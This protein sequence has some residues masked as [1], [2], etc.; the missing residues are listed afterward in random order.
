MSQ[1]PGQNVALIHLTKEERALLRH[2]LAEALGHLRQN[3]WRYMDAKPANLLW[4][5]ESKKVY[6]VDFE[7]AQ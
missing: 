6:I 1:L 5:K 4:D 3:G 2:D 7:D